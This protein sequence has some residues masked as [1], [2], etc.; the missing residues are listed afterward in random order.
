MLVEHRSP[1][2][3]VV[4]LGPE[5]AVGAEREERRGEDREDEEG[6]DRGDEDR[7]R[8]D[9]HPEH[10]HAGG[11]H[12]QDRR[13]E[14]D[15]AEDGPEAAEAEAEDPQVAAETGAVDRVA[16]RDVGEP[17]GGRRP[18]RGEEAGGGDEP[19]E[20]VEPVREHVQ[21]REGDVGAADL[22]RHQRVGEGREERGSE[23]QQH[24]RAVHRE[25]LVVLL[26]VVDDLQ[27]LGVEL[28]AQQQRHGSADHEPDE[29]GDE[30]EVADDLVVG[31]RHPLQDGRARQ[32]LAPRRSALGGAQ[33][34]RA[35]G[36]RAHAQLPSGRRSRSRSMSS[37][38]LREFGSRPVWPL[39]SRDWMCSS[40]SSRSTTLT[41]KS[42]LAW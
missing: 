22:Q 1:G 19:A 16:E 34:R 27:A 5:L 15:R 4:D 26:G 33:V 6:E 37:C 20:E 17:P 35:L 8:E 29:R 39:S 12:G 11:P 10:R 25:Q 38:M 21:P 42:M 40:Y 7:P 41:L 3:R 32:R 30:V 28:G 14:V 36:G 18:V 31:R 2:G 9:R 13:D 24:D 23:E